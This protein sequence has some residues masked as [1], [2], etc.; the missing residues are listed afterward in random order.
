VGWELNVRIVRSRH[1]VRVQA[2]GASRDPILLERWD[3]RIMRA[4]LTTDDALEGAAVSLSLA[5]GCSALLILCSTLVTAPKL[6]ATDLNTARIMALTGAKGTYDQSGRAF[7]VTIPRPDLHEEVR[8]MRLSPTT[9]L[10]DWAAFHST[11]P[12]AVVVG[13]IALTEDQ[14]SP[15]MRTALDQ[16][17]S[18]TSLQSRFIGE[19]PHVMFMH[20]LGVGDQESLAKSVGAVFTEVRRS[21]QRPKAGPGSVQMLP[22]DTTLD[23]RRLEEILGLRGDFEDGI[24]RVSAGRPNRP[25]GHPLGSAMGSTSRFA[26]SGVDKFAIVDADLLVL[27][28]A[29]QP[30]LRKLVRPGITITAIHQHIAG[31]EPQP[32][33]VLLHFWGRGEA[34]ALASALRAALDQTSR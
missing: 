31:Q 33:M 28:D 5:R 3:F 7:T 16:G 12:G 32:R 8:G 30:V 14:V 6:N 34:A 13:D 24:L 26:F 29:L 20:I 25:E 1:A 21:A 15:V 2:I 19:S 17:L 27:E 22:Q 4:E 9:G 18:V 23:I 11:G 10:T